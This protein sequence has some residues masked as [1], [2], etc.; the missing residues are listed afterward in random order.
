MSVVII[1]TDEITGAMRPLKDIQAEFGVPRSN[2][3]LWVKQNVLT[4]YKL[5]YNILFDR[6]DVAALVAMRTGDVEKV[7]D[8]IERLLRAAP[9]LSSEQKDR[10]AVLLGV[11]G[12]A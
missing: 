10:F 2:L 5:G 11:K 7:A 1:S 9:P 3:D 8:K 6:D 12:V 4:K